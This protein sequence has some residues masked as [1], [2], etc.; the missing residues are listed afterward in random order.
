MEVPKCVEQRALAAVQHQHGGRYIPDERRYVNTDGVVIDNTYPHRSC[1]LLEEIPP[2]LLANIALDAYGPSVR[3]F[4][5][6]SHP[7]QLEEAIA[8]RL[9]RRPLMTG[10]SLVCCICK[11]MIVTST[12]RGRGGASGSAPGAHVFSS[13][14]G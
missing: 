1:R 10:G 13:A 12:C 4:P 14:W 11:Q 7:P 8:T 5:L 6:F 2:H 9:R 3:T